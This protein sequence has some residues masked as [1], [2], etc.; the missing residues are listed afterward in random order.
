MGDTYWTLRVV[1]VDNVSSCSRAA[2]LQLPRCYRSDPPTGVPKQIISRGAY[3]VGKSISRF[4]SMS[5]I[6]SVGVGE[7]ASWALDLGG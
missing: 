4:A 1:A 3:G 7:K 5:E 6:G 2:R